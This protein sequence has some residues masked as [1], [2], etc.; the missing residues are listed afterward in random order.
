M[1]FRDFPGSLHGVFLQTLIKVAVTLKTVINKDWF[2]HCQ[3]VKCVS[4]PLTARTAGA[5]AVKE[6][7]TPWG[8]VPDRCPGGRAAHGQRTVLI[9]QA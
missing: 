9:T 7:A 4:A 5:P 2:Y 8:Q 6:P 1:Q 3:I